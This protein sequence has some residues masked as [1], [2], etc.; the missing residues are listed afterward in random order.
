[1]RSLAIV[2]VVTAHTVLAYGA[3][4]A[5]APLQLGG[6][7]V[8]LFFVLS[9]WLLGRQLMLELR[10]TGTIELRRFW[11]RR[12]M[13]TLPAYYAV[14]AATLLQALVLRRP[15]DLNWAYLVFGQNYVPHITAFYVS[16]S[17]CVEEH[18]YLLV[19]PVSLLVKRAG[20]W[21]FVVLGAILATPSICRISGLYVTGN[22]T[23]VRWDECSV[24]VALAAVS[25]FYPEAWSR[26]CRVAPWLACAGLALYVSNFWLRWHPEYGITSY[27]AG[28]YALIFGSWVLLANASPAWQ[29]RLYVPGAGYLATRAY[30][31]YLLHPD[32]LAL[33]KRA[34]IQSF[35]VLVLATWILTLCGAEL[36]YRIIELPIMRARERFRVSRSTSASAVAEPPYA[37]AALHLAAPQS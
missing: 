9:G 28:L 30:S 32:A 4:P 22:E 7:G 35:P 8:D 12:W 2:L 5:L 29:Q 26:L 6:T 1:L 19:G 3:P 25:V 33:L 16:W 17:L 21:N 18:F 20:R 23:H 14:L 11:S 34:N 10:K 37:P 31:V 36:L 24:G 15:S 27:D 13:R